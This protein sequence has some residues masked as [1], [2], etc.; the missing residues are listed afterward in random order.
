MRNKIQNLIFTSIVLVSGAAVKAATLPSPSVPLVTCAV[1][2]EAGGGRGTFKLWL[3][4]RQDTS[5]KYEALVDLRF[6]G[7]TV[8]DSAFF[9]DGQ[10]ITMT[11]VNQSDWSL[12]A[13]SLSQFDRVEQLDIQT[14]TKSGSLDYYGELE[15]VH[16]GTLKLERCVFENF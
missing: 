13:E 8:Q 5:N 16:F 9:M 1:K 2:G 6:R 12:T 15:R 11:A 10:I 14:K 7:A 3:V 4:K